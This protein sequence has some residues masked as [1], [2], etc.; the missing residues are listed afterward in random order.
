MSTQALF[1]GL[2][3]LYIADAFDRAMRSS[4]AKKSSRPAPQPIISRYPVALA[5]R[6]A[7]MVHA[8]GDGAGEGVPIVLGWR[9]R[10]G[11][12]FCRA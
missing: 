8:P 5:D 7:V 6:H 4:Q 10:P 2:A 12:S 11:W 9:A 1:N 3:A